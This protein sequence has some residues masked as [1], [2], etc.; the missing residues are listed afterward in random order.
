MRRRTPR[1]EHRTAAHRARDRRWYLGALFADAIGNGLWTPSALI[2]FTRAQGMSLGA[3]GAALTLGGVIGLLSIPLSGTLID[4]W[5]A[6][7]LI[8]LSNL[9]RGAVFL[10][11]PL[12]SSVWQ[13]TALA[14][15]LSACERLFWTANTP[16]LE[17]VVGKGDLL[18]L[19]GTQNMLRTV[20]WMAGAGLAALVSGALLQHPDRL[21]LIAWLN[22]ATFLTAALLTSGVR[23]PDR[24]TD[25]SDPRQTFAT[26]EPAWRSILTN[27]PFVTL[28]LTQLAFALMADS[29]A[30]MLPLVALDVLHGPPWL[31]AA[32]LIASSVSLLLVQRP[33]LRYYARQGSPLR[34]LRLA[35]VVFSVAFMLLA[36]AHRL[37][38][39]L[40]VPLVLTAAV[41][42]ACANALF[43]PVMTLLA[44]ETAPEQR[45]GHYSAIF[46]LAWGTAAVLAPAVGT[47]LL[48]AGNTVLWLTLGG[49]SGA[50]AALTSL[51]PPWQQRRHVHM[52]K[53]AQPCRIVIAGISGAGKTSLA[54][55]LSR[56]LGIRHIEMDALYY[57]P[58]W[59]RSAE[60]T[61]D[62]AQ[63]TA[64]EAWVCDAQYHW[65]VGDL[66]A[67][68]T[69][70]F[71]WLDLPRHTVMHRVIRRSFSRVLFRRRLWHGNTETWHTLLFSPRHPVRWAWT[72]YGTRR[73]ETA[74]YF[75]RHPEVPVVRLRTASQARRWLRSMLPTNPRP[76]GTDG[77]PTSS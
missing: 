54:A 70:L 60:F 32:A 67:A 25:P 49:L 5:G 65:I 51:I 23:L 10:A 61:N 21:H 58:H 66:L 14:A 74:A 64:S 72:Q 41:A 34:P 6:L 18:P 73:A 76:E 44:N 30:V 16:A 35:C 55:A 3:T 24:T 42:G 75:A 69:H 12:I 9:L 27:R 46:Q 39:A 37:T 33:S 48:T 36:P 62:V 59:S 68:R 2:F 20:G 19:L 22:G 57:G 56:R 52:A 28:C 17:R 50:T 45:K 63:V 26:A 38:S 4:R 29:L 43:A 8:Q 11:Y 1:S 15:V 31:P 40:A 7:P 53:Q 13:L 71:V 77:Q 47:F